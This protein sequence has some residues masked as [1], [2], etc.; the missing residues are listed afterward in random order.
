MS[1]RSFF[2]FLL[3]DSVW[4]YLSNAG[5]NYCGRK[6]SFLSA[7]HNK[8][9]RAGNKYNDVPRRRLN[10]MK[11]LED[12]YRD[13]IDKDLVDMKTGD[14]LRSLRERDLKVE[15]AGQEKLPRL[16]D[17]TTER[18]WHPE[19]V[20]AVIKCLNMVYEN[21]EA[22]NGQLTDPE[23]AGAFDWADFD[24]L[25]DDAGVMDFIVADGTDHQ[26]REK[27]IREIESWVRY[28]Q[29]KGDIKFVVN[30]GEGEVE[31]SRDRWRWIPRPKYKR[32]ATRTRQNIRHR[33]AHG[34]IPDKKKP[35]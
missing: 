22:G 3:F 10:E 5:V 31:E 28:H 2:L 7:L 13:V 25:A 8:K 17:P 21:K 11:E 12:K 29:K 4:S 23:R 30:M 33:K 32:G 1:L 35:F 9:G 26:E 24:A 15:F 6:P 20:D 34:L 19:M 14:D 27:V 16:Q 18:K